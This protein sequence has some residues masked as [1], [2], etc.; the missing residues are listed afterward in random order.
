MPPRPPAG[1]GS[2]RSIRSSPI[3]A[4]L[5]IFPVYAVITYF[6]L[7][8]HYALPTPLSSPVDIHGRAQISE[9]AILGYAK[10][11]SEEIGY[12]TV[13]T[14]EHA[15]ADRW[16]VEKAE[17]FKRECEEVVKKSARKLECEVWHQRGSGYH[18]HALLPY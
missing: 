12:R 13:G 15:R 5:L 18:R 17:A 9:A 2:V 1:T 8:T 10:Y 3:Y 7:R 11:L 14:V 16:M 4:I 6:T